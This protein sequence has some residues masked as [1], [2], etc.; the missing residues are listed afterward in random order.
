MNM[1]M[2]QTVGALMILGVFAGTLAGLL[3]VGGGIIII[4]GLLWLYESREVIPKDQIMHFALATSLATICFTSITSIRAHNKR[5]AVLWSFV[6]KMSPGIVIGALIGTFLA[7]LLSSVI[8]VIFFGI[9]LL[10]VSLQM[11]LAVQPT[12]H[13]QL[14][15]W[16]GTSSIGVFIGVI[17]ALV[18]VGGGTL[19]VPFLTWC[20]IPVRTAIA[21]SSAVGFFIAVAGAVGFA[22]IGHDIQM[23]LSTGYIYWPAVAGIVP[24]SLVFAPLGAKLAHTI[25]V[26]VLKSLFSIFLAIIGIKLIIKTYPSVNIDEFIIYL[27][28]ASDTVVNYLY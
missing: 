27:H 21:S 3:G 16:F 25:P 7:G 12:S 13:R 4:P 24:T 22:F 5:G 8:L 19:T 11:G 2:M 1:L 17:S 20:N 26:K 18:G 9:F 6:L 28:Q 14:P 10:F 23:P 15:N